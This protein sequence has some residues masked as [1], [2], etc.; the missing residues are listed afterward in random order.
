MSHLVHLL[1]ESMGMEPA[2]SE[3]I[4]KA[5]RY[6]DI[7]KMAIPRHI[8][9]SVQPLTMKE[10]K[11]I[12]KHVH[13]G[14]LFLSSYRGAEMDM[15]R[16]IIAT[17]HEHW[18]GNGYPKGLVADEI[19]LCGRI[20]AICDV[21]DALCSKRPYKEAW[22]HEMAL[23]YMDERRGTQFDPSLVDPFIGISKSILA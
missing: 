10:R 18:D 4:S 12:E 23:A 15:A 1:C 20:V 17:H 5:S 9:D 2:E 11:I 22:P 13:Y 6:H 3:L 8:L 7:G 21:Y 16:D 14:L 19:P